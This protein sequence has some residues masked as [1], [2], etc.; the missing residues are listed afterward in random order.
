[1]TEQQS[2]VQESSRQSPGRFTTSMAVLKQPV[3][4][5][6]ELKEHQKSK[7]QTLWSLLIGSLVLGTIVVGTYA[8][9]PH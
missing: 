9:L 5:A 7:R 4:F 1:M 3:A 2:S 8:L 6:S